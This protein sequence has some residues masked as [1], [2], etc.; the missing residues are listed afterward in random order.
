[1]VQSWTNQ[2]RDTTLILAVQEECLGVLYHQP[3]QYVLLG[4]HQFGFVPV[5]AGQTPILQRFA[6]PDHDYP[7]LSSMSVAVEP[8]NSLSFTTKRSTA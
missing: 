2:V 1:M 8:G 5:L 7:P 4:F 6:I 3:Y